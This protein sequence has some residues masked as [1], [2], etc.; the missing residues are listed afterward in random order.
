[1]YC[2]FCTDYYPDQPIHNTCIYKNNILYNV[3]TSTYFD[4]PTLSSIYVYIS[5]YGFYWVCNL[6]EFYNFSRVE[7]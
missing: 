1:M 2:A 6:K 4:S 3:S 5:V 7:G